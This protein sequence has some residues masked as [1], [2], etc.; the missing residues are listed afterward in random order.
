MPYAQRLEQCQAEAAEQ[1][2]RFA[3]R[4]AQLPDSKQQAFVN[5]RD[6][7][8][9]EYALMLCANRNEYLPLAAF[10]ELA[11]WLA[12]FLQKK[13]VRIT[14]HARALVVELDDVASDEARV[15]LGQQAALTNVRLEPLEKVLA[16]KKGDKSLAF[17]RTRERNPARARAALEHPPRGLR[18][19]ERDLLVRRMEIGLS[20]DDIPFLEHENALRTLA[21]LPESKAYRELGEEATRWLS[22]S[23]GALEV[24]LPTEF[25]ALFQR[26][27][28]TESSIGPQLT[29]Q[30]SWLW[31]LI[32]STP[33]NY[34]ENKWQLS[35]AGILD[36][37]AA[38]AVGKKF[39][40]ALNNSTQRYRDR[41]WARVFLDRCEELA[42]PLGWLV[43]EVLEGENALG[44]SEM[45]RQYYQSL[46]PILAAKDRE[47]Y[48]DEILDL[49]P[50]HTL[51]LFN[52]ALEH[53]FSLSFSERELTAVAKDVERGGYTGV[54]RKQLIYHLNSGILPAI[55]KLIPLKTG[56][57]AMVRD[58][59]TAGVQERD[60]IRKAFGVLT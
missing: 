34:L 59:L 44:L 24:K 9:L 16:S 21:L 47:A 25:N 40:D 32:D 49:E 23:R 31:Q 10:Q 46:I 43:P 19:D 48:C 20:S 38:S 37:F 28:F 7:H 26:L 39:I 53:V 18:P 33:L 29:E 52:D 6:L 17:E 50:N 2:V 60:A 8:L 45:K 42:G 27:N 22:V 13:M 3:R 30:E 14:S 57:A 1:I 12:P 51:S 15:W 4:A 41:A 54:D 56:S 36:S 55:P 58:D 35:P 5:G 11:T